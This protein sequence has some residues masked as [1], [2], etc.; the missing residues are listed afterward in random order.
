MYIYIHIYILL[1]YI[2]IYIL[3]ADVVLHMED[4]GI[5]ACGDYQTVNSLKAL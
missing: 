4:E 2:C 3:D 5:S 1:I